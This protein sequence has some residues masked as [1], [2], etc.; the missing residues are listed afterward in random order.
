MRSAHLCFSFALLQWLSVHPEMISPR[1]LQV[2]LIRRLVL[3]ANNQFLRP[4]VS[5]TEL[6][7][8]PF[9]PLRA[10]IVAFAF[11]WIVEAAPFPARWTWSHHRGACEVKY[12]LIRCSATICISLFPCCSLYQLLLFGQEKETADVPALVLVA[13]VFCMRW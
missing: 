5:C 3:I 7:T 8:K 4:W 9:L 11:C 2:L 10:F 6:V 12:Y 1:F 13:C